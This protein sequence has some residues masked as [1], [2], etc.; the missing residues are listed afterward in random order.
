MILGTCNRFISP[1][2]QFVA[3]KRLFLCR[4][5]STDQNK[6]RIIKTDSKDNIL[7]L[8]T[9]DW[10]FKEADIKFRTLF[11]WRNGPT[12]V[13][14]KHQNPFKECHLQKMEQDGVVLSRRYSGGGAV[15]QDLGNTNFTILSPINENYKEKNAQIIINALARFGVTATASGRNDILV[16]GLKVSGSAYKLNSP[17]ALHHGTLMINVDINALPKYLNPNKAKLQ[18]KG[19][20]S[21]ASRVQNLKNSNPEITHETLCNAIAEEFKKANNADCEI[22]NV[23]E[24]ELLNIPAIKETYEKLKDWNWRYGTTPHFNHH[25]ETRFDWGI[26]DVHINSAEGKISEVKIFSDSLFPT[27]IED[28]SNAL[29]GVK[30]LGKPVTEA[31]AVVEKKYT[32]N[33]CG[34]YVNQFSSWLVH[35]M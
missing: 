11:L 12:V 29:I 30:Y 1:L 28:I 19:I 33:D 32:E 24:K 10:I 27:M 4:A 16:N 34:K 23:T 13:I 25:L 26:M 35:H 7:N 18:S 22:E 6:I 15:Y 21:V 3:H 8:A 2:P 5:Y 17:R 31:L 20:T 9:E 14:G